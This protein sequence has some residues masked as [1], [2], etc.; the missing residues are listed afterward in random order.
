[1]RGSRRREDMAYWILRLK[2]A[3]EPGQPAHRTTFSTEFTKCRN[4]TGTHA[5]PLLWSLDTST[6]PL[7]LGCKSHEER[8]VLLELIH[9]GVSSASELAEMMS[10]N[11]G[12]ISR[13]AHRLAKAGL[14]TIR[15]R[16]YYPANLISPEP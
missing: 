16:Q 8:D 5:R 2:E 15:N 11:A 1:M 10:I 4:C 13:A 14:I 6:T 7:T 3:G 9:S 12:T